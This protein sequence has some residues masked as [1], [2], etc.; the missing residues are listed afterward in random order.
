MSVEILYTILGLI[1]MYTTIHFFVIQF[2]KAWANRTIY[3]K[4]VTIVGI[5]SISLVYIGIIGGNY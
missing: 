1:M 2:M 3:E 5:V 4:I